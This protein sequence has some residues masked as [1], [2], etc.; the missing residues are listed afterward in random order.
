MKALVEQQ[1]FQPISHEPQGM[2]QE[3]RVVDKR[4]D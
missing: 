1:C 4:E 3:I 2:G